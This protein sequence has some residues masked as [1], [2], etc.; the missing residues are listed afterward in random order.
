MITLIVISSGVIFRWH[1][2]H[3]IMIPKLIQPANGHSSVGTL[4][5]HN[6]YY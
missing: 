5:K 4:G 3:F 2:Q 6:D 1:I